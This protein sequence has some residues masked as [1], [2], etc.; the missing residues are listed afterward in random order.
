LHQ[1]FT[2][3]GD[4]VNED[5]VK[6]KGATS[7]FAAHSAG[8]R[9]HSAANQSSNIV[10]EGESSGLSHLDFHFVSNLISIFQV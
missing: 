9:R 7:A 8:V 5:V 6:V 2:A 4:A 3:D 10:V 1:C